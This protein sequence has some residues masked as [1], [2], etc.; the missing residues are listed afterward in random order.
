MQNIEY[1]E[2]GQR[3][4]FGDLYESFLRD[5][6][7]A[8]DSGEYYTPRAITDLAIEMLDPKLGESILDPAAGTGGFLCSATRHVKTN[9]VIPG[10]ISDN[11]MLMQSINGV[12]KKAL[13]TVLCMT[14]LI[15][16][17]IDDPGRVK[18]GN[19]LKKPINS[20][21]EDDE[22]DIIATNPPFGGNEQDSILSNFPI[23]YRLSETADLFMSVI[24]ASLRIGG[25]AAV[26]YPD[27]PAPSG[28]K[29][30]IVRRLV[31]ECNL[32][33]IIQLPRTTFAPYATI[34][35]NVLFFTKGTPT[36]ETWFYQHRVPKN[37][38]HYNKTKPII[39]EHLDPIREWWGDR[40]ES[41]YSWKVTV[42][43][44]VNAGYGIFNWENP[45]LPEDKIREV[46]TILN[47]YRAH[48][49]DVS[50]LKT[51]FIQILQDAIND[52]K[53]D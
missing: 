46:K 8:K 37:Q 22:V 1:D 6:Q 10:S 51:N 35:T 5:L 3:D 32:H 14:N 48:K 30:N 34:G 52:S 25:R 41:E 43:E 4:A 53:S 16:H 9:Y 42:E 45:N 47:Q 27:T 20:Y 36:T 50:S 11:E 21:T 40:K 39:S 33:T 49:E 38:M 26:V 12:E 7:A 44:I 15:H 13:P 17:G 29:Q 2:S 24:H 31:E 18:R 28:K 19:S 23:A